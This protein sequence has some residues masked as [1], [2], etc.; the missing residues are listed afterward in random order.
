MSENLLT[1]YQVLGIAATATERDIKS[2]YRKAAR[3]AHPDH[4]GDPAAFLLVTAAY[5]T[6]INPQRRAA[7]DRSYGVGSQR[8]PGWYQPS[9]PAGAGASATRAAGPPSATSFAMGHA[10]RAPKVNASDPAVYVPAFTDLA[11]GTTP[12]L[13]LPRAAQ[14]VHEAPRKRGVFGAQARLAREART[15]QLV[16][17]QILPQIPAARLVNGLLSPADNGYVDHVLLSGYRMV[18]IGS[19]L[20][21]EGA[22]RFN[23]SSL[24][25]GGKVIEPPRML[26]AVRTMQQV[27]PDCNVTG[28]ICV[29]SP[30]GNLYQPVIDYAPGA[31]PDGSTLVNAVNG[32]RLIR[33]VRHFLAAGPAPNVVDLS[34]LSR[35][36]GGMY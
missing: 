23:G 10:Q 35:L 21:P 33:E 1:H 12:L 16:M 15:I 9:S 3:L 27:F 29:H 17:A 4:G 13:P 5:E 22:Y 31:E 8:R 19:M 20:L 36:L 26:P 18:L 28:W 24:L 2:A 32:S 11:A 7:Y 25:H 6:L 34:V 30:E 14:Q